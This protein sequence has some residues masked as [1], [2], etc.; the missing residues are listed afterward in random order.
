MLWMGIH[1]WQKLLFSAQTACRKCLGRITGKAILHQNY[2][3][4]IIF[5]I[6][7]A[8]ITSMAIIYREV[9]AFWPVL[10]NCLI[11]RFTHVQYNADSVLI[12]ISLNALMCVCC[13]TRNYSVRTRCILCLFKV[14]QRVRR[15]QVRNRMCS[16]CCMEI[17]TSCRRKHPTPNAGI[18]V[19]SCEVFRIL[20]LI[21]WF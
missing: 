15:L 12:I 21:T 2:L 16:A 10:G 17:W 4:Q 6:I 8:C 14:S 20:W 5:K 19:S 1:I 18:I 3:V 7:S 11:L 9:A 13:V